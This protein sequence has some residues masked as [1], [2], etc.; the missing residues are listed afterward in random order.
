V[1]AYT[2]FSVERTFLLLAFYIAGFEILGYLGYFPGFNFGYIYKISYPIFALLIFYWIIYLLHSGERWQSNQMDIAVA[3]VMLVMFMGIVQGYL[4]GYQLRLIFTDSE[5]QPF[6]L[7][8]FIFLY[9]SLKS[10]VKKY[11]DILLII[12]IFVSLQFIYAVAHFKTA[13]FLKRIVSTHIHIAQFAVPY[14]MTTIIYSASRLRKL[15]FTIALPLVVLAVVFCQQ[16]S[17][18]LSTFL[19]I[20]VLLGVFLYTKRGWIKKNLVRSCMYT[21]ILLVL[22]A[23][24]IAVMQSATDGKFLRTLYIRF[25][26]FM[27]PGLLSRE[28]S[29]YIRWQEVKSALEGLEHFW[30][31]GKGFGVSQISRFRYYVQVVLDNSYVY[32]IW[33]TGITGLLCALFMYFLHFKRG[34][35]T[36]RKKISVD[37]KIFL[38]TALANTAGMMFLTFANV[39]VAFFRHIYIWAG[40]LAC[41]EVI[42]RK[43]E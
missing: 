17:L 31:L 14:I 36:L 20:V 41:V 22:I 7:V 19:T 12:A 1:L 6:Y 9:S 35:Q 37:D 43:Y 15:L 40:L 11:Y 5:S 33:K 13:F 42:A 21:F 23:I 30:P 8:Y 27:K 34:I 39:S 2:A 18:Y 38:I 4:Q 24:V 29:W 26:I 25:L 3:V 10:K 16:R 28:T 32:W